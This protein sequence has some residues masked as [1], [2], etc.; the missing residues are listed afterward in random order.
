MLTG[1]NLLSVNLNDHQFLENL[2]QDKVIYLQPAFKA[3]K[4]LSFNSLT[5]GFP[6]VNLICKTYI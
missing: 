1:Y 2:M 5:Y 6:Y 4:Q 3:N